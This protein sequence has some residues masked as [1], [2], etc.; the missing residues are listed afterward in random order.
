M[1]EAELQKELARLTT[2]IATVA[3]QIECLETQLASLK[4]WTA[5]QSDKPE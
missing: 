4:E 3:L 2:E 5:V 1:N